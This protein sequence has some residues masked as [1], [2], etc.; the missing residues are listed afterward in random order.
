MDTFTITAYS[1]ATDIVTFNATIAGQTYTGL[2]TTGAP[3]DSVASVKA[4]F[5][6]YMDAYIQGKT[7]EANK[8]QNSPP[9]VTALL[10]VATPFV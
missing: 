10:N 3:K 2:K 9:E 1:S 8:V 7:I 4:F 5:K 6:S